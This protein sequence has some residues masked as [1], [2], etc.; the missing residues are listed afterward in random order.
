M[1]SYPFDG[2]KSGARLTHLGNHDMVQGFDDPYDSTIGYGDAD[3]YG[4]GTRKQ[5]D[6]T[7]GGGKPQQLSN[8]HESRE[9]LRQPTDY[10]RDYYELLRKFHK[11]RTQSDNPSAEELFGTYK[12]IKNSVDNV[13]E[14][15]TKASQQADSMGKFNSNPY[16]KRAT[17]SK[18][19]VETQMRLAGKTFNSNA[20]LEDN[21]NL[22]SKLEIVKGRDPDSVRFTIKSHHNEYNEERDLFKKTEQGVLRRQREIEMKKRQEKLEKKQK[23]VKDKYEK[24]ELYKEREPDEYEIFV[25]SVKKLH[26]QSKP[27]DKDYIYPQKLYE[28]WATL[29][30]DVKKQHNVE[31]DKQVVHE[32]FHRYYNTRIKCLYDHCAKQKGTKTED[33]KVLFKHWKEIYP[34]VE[35]KDKDLDFESD[36]NAKKIIEDWMNL[37][38]REQKERR[39]KMLAEMDAVKVEEKKKQEERKAKETKDK[40]PLNKDGKPMTEKELK[41]EE[42]EKKMREMANPKERLI[43]GKTVVELRSQFPED[44][45]LRKMVIDEFANDR[46]VKRPLEYDFVDSDE[47]DLRKGKIVKRDGKNKGN[48]DEKVKWKTQEEIDADRAKE[49]TEKFKELTKKY[50]SDKN[51]ALNTDQ[52]DSEK[53]QKE[54]EKFEVF[55]NARVVQYRKLMQSKQDQVVPTET[56]YLSDVIS[57]LF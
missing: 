6:I 25:R 37:M 4:L 53:L 43:R 48:K 30:P 17:S 23:A 55:I 49:L 27:D 2:G 31:K 14:A 50:Q 54:R 44:R 33:P 52:T 19:S 51:E 36:D 39:D 5:G 16:Q 21:K 29:P 45:I 40:A 34:A 15:K 28:F 35:K 42:Q 12:I 46:I 24:Q 56:K 47:E 26:K 41:K 57:C 22:E 11:D 38:K 18:I 10:G 9:I 32:I 13:K 7:P 8:L 20:G 3:G 1:P